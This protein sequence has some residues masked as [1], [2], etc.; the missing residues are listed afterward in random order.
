MGN[1]KNKT[2]KISDLTRNK[3]HKISLMFNDDLWLLFKQ[4]CQDNKTKP[5]WEIEKWI[6]SYLD[7]NNKL[8]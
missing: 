3:C 2:E 8:D 7:R 1:E 6:L 5:T 4:T